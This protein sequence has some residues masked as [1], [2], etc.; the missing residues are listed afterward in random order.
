MNKEKIDPQIQSDLFAANKEKVISAIEKI[1]DKGNE[2]YLPSLFELLANTQEEEITA[3]IQ[4]LL[5]TVKSK[6]AIPYFAEALENEKL[7]PAQKSIIAACWQNG[8][9][10]ADYLPIFVEIV[11]NE[12]WETAFEAFTVIENIDRLP[13]PDVTEKLTRRINTALETAS[14]Q[15]RYFLEEILVKIG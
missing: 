6:E 13:Q 12:E 4:K 2:L 15:N 8:L 10:F 1:K 7:K 11:I 9:D 14:G 3:E 5:G